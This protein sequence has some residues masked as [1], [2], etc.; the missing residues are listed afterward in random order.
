MQ[1]RIFQSLTEISREAWDG[2]LSPNFPFAR[3]E[4]LLALEQAGCVG[5]GL[6]WVPAYFTLWE[7]DRL[8]G[9]SYLYEREDSFGEFIFD[10]DWA[11]A[12]QRYDL[13]YY[14]K[15]VA[16]IPFT[17]ATGPKLLAAPL[18]KAPEIY[19]ELIR[20][21]LDWGEARRL[22]SLH[23]L[24]IPDSEVPIFENAD[25]LLRHSYQF[26][27]VNRNYRDFQDFLDSMKRK[28]RQAIQ[29]ER[30]RVDEAGIEI[31]ALTGNQ[32]DP[33][34]GRLMYRLS[35]A[36]FLKKNGTLP[37][38]GEAF[39]EEIFRTFRENILLILAKKD[40]QWVAGAINFFQ[41]D[42]LFGRYWGC[43]EE[44]RFLHF[45]LCYYQA[46][47]YAIRH[48]FRLYEAGAGGEHKLQR[49]FLPTLTYSAHWIRHPGF[50][51]AIGRFIEM[52][53]QWIEE[54]VAALK[55]HQPYKT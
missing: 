29:V 31:H 44:Y 24:F 51:K 17:P 47:D 18:A 52:E 39:F 8:M 45:E 28:R 41:G 50:A 25:F 6:A 26:H 32:L 54:G 21:I 16:A 35:S 36:T 15:G 2:L 27:W 37:Y 53:K 42:A 46:I 33:E 5:P 4:F 1:V 20:A 12:Y 19:S 14:P 34:L 30:R 10:F 13:E 48:G 7:Q 40:G 23:F 9:G 43:L 22:S 49:G 3:H 38:L 11:Q 55:R